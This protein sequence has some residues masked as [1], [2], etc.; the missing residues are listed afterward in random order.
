MAGKYVKVLYDLD[1]K[2]HE[3]VAVSIREGEKCLLLKKTNADWWSVV[4]EG[5]KKPIYVPANYVED[6]VPATSPKPSYPKKQPVPVPPKP[7]TNGN[8]VTSEEKESKETEQPVSKE[9]NDKEN[10]LKKENVTESA[11]VEEKS[12]DNDRK[13]PNEKDQDD[14]EEECDYVNVQE[15]KR[16]FSNASDDQ[17]EEVT[18]IKR[19]TVSSYEPVEY[20]NLAVIQESIHAKKQVSSKGRKLVT[21][22]HYCSQNE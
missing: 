10:E 22:T 20:A 12:D 16:Q 14:S 9:N 7:K 21:E 5:D 6:I 17:E 4:R 1:Y 15:L 3:G 8:V 18:G 13:T 19:E 2:T 11:S